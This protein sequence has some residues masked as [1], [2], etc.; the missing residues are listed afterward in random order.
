M[1]SSEYPFEGSPAVC[2]TSCGAGKHNG[3]AHS[4]DCLINVPLA[5]MEWWRMGRRMRM[6]RMT[7]PLFSDDR[8]ERQ[9]AFDMGV[10]SAKYA[11]Q[12]NPKQP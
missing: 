8:V 5:V 10:R 11:L 7:F 1:R 12:T 9:K 3:N 6:Q 2:C 4:E